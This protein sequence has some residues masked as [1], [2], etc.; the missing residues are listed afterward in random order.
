MSFARQTDKAKS[1]CRFAM[2]QIYSWVFESAL[3]IHVSI[4]ANK[5]YEPS[6]YIRKKLSLKAV[7]YRFEL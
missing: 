6:I 4:P 5:R 1:Q 3:Y 2:N 7:Y